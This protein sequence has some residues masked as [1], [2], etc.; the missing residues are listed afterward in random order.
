MNIKNKLIDRYFKEI[1]LENAPYTNSYNNLY[2]N[3]NKQLKEQEYKITLNGAE[4]SACLCV[5]S[6]Y[7][8]I[9][10][11]IN[12]I[13]GEE[14]DF[15]NKIVNSLKKWECEV[16]VKSQ[17]AGLKKFIKQRTSE[18]TNDLILFFYS[19]RG[20]FVTR[21]KGNQDILA[22]QTLVCAVLD[23]VTAL[24][25]KLDLNKKFVPKVAISEDTAIPLSEY[26]EK[27][28]FGDMADSIESESCR[29]GIQAIFEKSKKI[30]LHD[31]RQNVDIYV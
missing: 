17:G 24:Y 4:Y 15:C 19:L 29:I 20:Y 10:G 27:K 13:R 18:L 1:L 12:L 30:M 6:M 23:I 5:L 25:Q 8:Y 21:E 9:D 3:I 2:K 22:Y 28:Y 26:I 11:F 16:F 14:L 31:L 7:Q